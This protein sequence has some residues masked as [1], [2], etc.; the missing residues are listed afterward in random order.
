MKSLISINDID[1]TQLLTL[2]DRAK[3]LKTQGFKRTLP[4]KVIASLFFEPSTR[5]KMSFETA[6]LRTGASALGFSPE[7]S[8]LKKGESLEDT[9]RMVSG[10]ADLIVMRH[11]EEN[12]SS[13]A[14][15]VSKCPII[16]AG[17]GKNEHP[18][19]TLLDLYTI[20]EDHHSLDDF[21]ITLA[22]DL[23]YSRTIHSLIYAI[24]KFSNA[25]VILASPEALTL[26][27]EFRN[28]LG[29]RLIKETHSL[30]E[31]LECDYFYMTRVQKERFPNPEDAHYEDDW[32]LTHDHCI[33]HAKPT[34]KILHPLPRVN[35]ISTD[36]DDTPFQL[37]FKQAQNGLYVRIALLEFLL[38][39]S[40]ATN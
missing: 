30:A 39:E 33:K 40:N 28:I 25:K 15:A 34:T 17:D 3:Q 20:L 32:I 12:A 37:Y 24:V 10:Y 23:K 18:T 8:S 6:I 2:F 21:V 26:S 31:G 36:I 22:G 16:N 5:T 4:N 11:P 19:Q 7:N 1:K 29:D 13:R 35:E 9:I 38:G 14:K 27:D